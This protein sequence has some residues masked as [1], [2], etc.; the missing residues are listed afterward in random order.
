MYRVL[1]SYGGG[2]ARA[3]RSSLLGFTRELLDGDILQTLSL[4]SAITTDFIAE[5]I[6]KKETSPSP[7]VPIDAKF[8]SYSFINHSMFILKLWVS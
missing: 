3:S 7:F 6:Y 1:L 2:E 8:S 4:L 5:I